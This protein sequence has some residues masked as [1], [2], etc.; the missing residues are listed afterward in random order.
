MR[1][2]QIKI[3]MRK[4]PHSIPIVLTDFSMDLADIAQLPQRMYNTANLLKQLT[5]STGVKLY[6]VDKIFNEIYFCPKG[7]VV[8]GHRISWSI[9]I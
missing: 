5:E 7:D 4:P 9:S 1:V 2:V 3:R 6:L 8:S